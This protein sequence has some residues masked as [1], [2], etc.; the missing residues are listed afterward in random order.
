MWDVESEANSQLFFLNNHL[1]KKNKQK[2]AEMQTQTHNCEPR[3]S[4]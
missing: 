4:V 2:K 1:V 3:F